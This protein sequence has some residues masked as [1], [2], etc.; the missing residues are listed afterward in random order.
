MGCP[1]PDLFEAKDSAELIYV[2]LIYC[3][4]VSLPQARNCHTTA[5]K[6]SGANLNYRARLVKWLT[7]ENSKPASFENQKLFITVPIKVA[8]IG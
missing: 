2:Y 7:L 3:Q 6:K 8:F 4:L 1:S 5:E